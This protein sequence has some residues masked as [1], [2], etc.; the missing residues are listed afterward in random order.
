MKLYNFYSAMSSSN[1]VI[2]QM[3]NTL[4]KHSENSLLSIAVYA[5]IQFTHINLNQ[6]NQPNLEHNPYNFPLYRN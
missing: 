5:K 2:E 6:L 3:R 1:R 4:V